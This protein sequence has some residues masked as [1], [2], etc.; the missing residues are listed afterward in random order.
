[1]RSAVAFWGTAAAQARGQAA[2]AARTEVRSW[3][4]KSVMQA[5]VQFCGHTSMLV[6]ICNST[7]YCRP[8]VFSWGG[9]G[10][11]CRFLLQQ[12]S[13][14]QCSVS[15]HRYLVMACWNWTRELYVWIIYS[16]I[17]TPVTSLLLT[18]PFPTPFPSLTAVP[19]SSCIFKEYLTEQG[20]SEIQKIVHKGAK[21][22]L[23]VW[24]IKLIV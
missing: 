21:G 5:K 3:L 6:Q 15:V 18:F 24:K 23:G 14:F 7:G 16:R 17:C 11:P 10:L 12:F 19:P 8:V 1:M 4:C 13:S 2:W 22:L 9:V 20:C